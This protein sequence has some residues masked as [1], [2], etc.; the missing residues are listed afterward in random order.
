MLCVVKP[1]D[2]RYVDPALD[3]NVTLP[4]AQNVVGPPAVMVGCAGKAFT[5][6]FVAV[7]ATL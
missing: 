4:P 7:E 3:D 5:V 1:F 2:H 6:T